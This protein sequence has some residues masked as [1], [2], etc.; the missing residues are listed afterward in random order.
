MGEKLGRN[1]LT[2]RTEET[3]FVVSKSVGV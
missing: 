3:N 2:Q 1:C